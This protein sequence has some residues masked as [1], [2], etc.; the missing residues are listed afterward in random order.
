VLRPGA[1]GLFD[2]QLSGHVYKG[3]IFPFNLLVRL[4][5]PVRTGLTQLVSSAWLY[6]S[7]GTGTWGPPMRVAALPEI[8]L[9]EIQ[10][11][12]A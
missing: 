1:A 9:I 2:R 5:Y 12:A 3:R 10:G 8:T 11:S 6:V 7:R 4:A